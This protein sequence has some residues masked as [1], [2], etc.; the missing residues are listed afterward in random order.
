M[1]AA[2]GDPSLFLELCFARA[3]TNSIF[4]ADDGLKDQSAAS[5]IFLLF[6]AEES[7]W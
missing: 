6:A 2:N 3:N 4:Q 1:Q 7:G 5:G